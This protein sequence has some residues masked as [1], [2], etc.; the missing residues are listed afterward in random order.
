MRQGLIALLSKNPSMDV[1][2]AAKALGVAPSKIRAMV[3]GI[4]TTSKM[5]VGEDLAEGLSQARPVGG[6]MPGVRAPTAADILASKTAAFAKGGGFVEDAAT[7][8]G[9]AAGAAGVGKTV[10]TP[11]GLVQ[12]AG[13]SK[14]AVVR[15]AGQVALASGKTA[16]E[17]A[18]IGRNALKAT[19]GVGGKLLGAGRVLPWVG[20]V[21]GAYTLLSMLY[22]MTAGRT[23]SANASA[24]EDSMDIGSL[25]RG[26]GE[27]N[28]QAQEAERSNKMLSSRMSTQG[29]VGAEQGRGDAELM[30]LI[31]GNHD[32][33]AQLQG[34]EP[35]RLDPMEIAALADVLYSRI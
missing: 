10:G 16:E 27:Q 31:G 13:S 26:I 3:K 19:K 23:A 8:G 6:V 4:R 29:L 20:G 5:R 30:S 34:G 11:P 15:A 33:L 24:A 14:A 1:T 32:R 7:V 2:D 17:A 21:I 35:E 28:N 18:V 25:L 22:D 12:V 9:L